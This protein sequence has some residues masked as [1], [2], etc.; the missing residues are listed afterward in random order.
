[1]YR[2][3]EAQEGNHQRIKSNH[4]RYSIGRPATVVGELRKDCLGVVP[5][6]QNPERYHDGGGAH[7]VEYQHHAFDKRQFLG[8]ESIEED[9]EKPDANHDQCS[10]PRL[11]FVRRDIQ[12]DQTLGHGSHEEGVAHEGGLPTKEADPSWK[13]ASEP[14]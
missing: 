8:Q 2:A 1:M 6:C 9:G 7:D 3:V 11:W 13:N 4:E 12:R 5:R 14:V 10:V